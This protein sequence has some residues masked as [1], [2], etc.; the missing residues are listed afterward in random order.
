MADLEPSAIVTCT[1]FASGAEAGG[2]TLFDR[3]GVPVFQAVVATTRREAWQSG[4]RGL[5]PSDLAMHVVMPELDGRVL[6][7]VV[8]FKSRQESTA[9]LGFGATLN[10]PEPDRVDQV[11]ARIALSSTSLLP[12]R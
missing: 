11:A 10:L 6:A 7:G 12:R 2:Q 4:P 3:A 5:A 1:A 9:E 8:S